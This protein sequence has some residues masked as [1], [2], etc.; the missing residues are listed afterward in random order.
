MMKKNRRLVGLAAGLLLAA[1]LLTPAAA[2]AWTP[3]A[4]SVRALELPASL[5]HW[6]WSDLR[7][8][9]K[10]GAGMDPDGAPAL[11]SAVQ[12][13]PQGEA[14]AGMDPDGVTQKEGA[15]M[16]PN[17]VTHKGGADMDPDG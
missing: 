5:W 4:L 9:T 2:T 14:G 17:G 10:E 16:D 8:A 3:G 7:L 15:D 13:P 1:A 11:G 6:L 12:S